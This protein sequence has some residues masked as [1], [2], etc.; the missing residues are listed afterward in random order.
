MRTN[1]NKQRAQEKR[2]K[3]REYAKAI[4]KMNEAERNALVQSWPTTIEGHPVS[5]HNA[6]LLA[7]QG[8]ATVIGG[9]NQWKRAGR[10]VRK[11]EHGKSI[12]IPLGFR[13]KT[14]ENGET[15]QEGEKTG[16]GLASVFDISQTEANEAQGPKPY[17]IERTLA[18]A[19]QNQRVNVL[20]LA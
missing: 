3:L 8:G 2:Q 6:C 7:Y 4:S 14:D 5:V 19:V 12:W 11:G 13:K 16:F 17:A 15:T 1:E 9:F 18:P 20:E 10:Y